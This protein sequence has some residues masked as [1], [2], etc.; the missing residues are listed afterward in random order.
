MIELFEA[1]GHIPQELAT[2]II[3]ESLE[4]F[5]WHKEAT[6]DMATYKTLEASHPLIADI[7][8]LK[9]PHINHLTP[10]VLDIDAAQVGMEK[11]G[12][13][14]KA[15][16]EGPPPRK[17]LILLRQTSFLALEE[18]IAFSNGAEQG[19]KH[20]AR[21][22][23]I[24]QRGVALTPKGRRLYDEMLVRSKQLIGKRPSETHAGILAQS[25]S[26]FPDDLNTLRQENLAYFKYVVQNISKSTPKG[27]SLD[28]LVS[29]EVL[30]V[31]PITY[32]DFL[33]VS[34]AG[35]FR[36][37]LHSKCNTSRG[38]SSDQAAFEMALG[39]RVRDPFELYN[40]LEKAPIDECL[41]VLAQV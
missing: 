5:R 23:E 18:E 9:G 6:V 13:Q 14:A 17:H 25:F 24:E 35:I 26:K 27:A 15:A 12:L 36:S 1:Q 40:P 20:R 33:P 38:V 34:A 31:E 4:T 3:K 10:R 19:G 28:Y 2:E 22:G 11:A 41:E 16:I 29:S 21:F 32:E 8:C 7:I 30:G 37:N 39:C